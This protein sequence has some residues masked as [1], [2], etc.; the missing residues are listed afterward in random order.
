MGKKI[1]K[2]EMNKNQ[3]YKKIWVHEFMGMPNSGKTSLIKII[4]PCLINSG[5]K[6]KIIEEG[7]RRCPLGKKR[8]F[9]YNLW[10]IADTIKPLLETVTSDVGKTI[11]L[12]D[13]GPH[14][15]IPFTKTLFKHKYLTSDQTIFLHNLAKGLFVFVDSISVHLCS[16][17][18]SLS[19][20][21]SHSIDRKGL[22]MNLPFLKDLYKSYCSEKWGAESKIIFGD[23]LVLEEASKELVQR[24]LNWSK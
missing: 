8:L 6:V 19:R 1:V 3:P 9:N 2:L 20:D 22:V 23:D 11:I 24:I 4:G 13:R 17:N 14:D 18:I 10:G 5:Y 16:P 15:L 21:E 12:L 7:I